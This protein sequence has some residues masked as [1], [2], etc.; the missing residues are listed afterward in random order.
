MPTS[1]ETHAVDTSVAVAA[2]DASHAAHDICRARVVALRP[3]LAGN[4]ASESF[5]VLTRMPGQLSADGATAYAVLDRAFPE[6]CW[7]S[8]DQAHRLLQRCAEMEVVGG[9]FYEALVGESARVA[10]RRLLTRD[11]RARRIYDLLG[12]DYE[13]VGL[14]D[15]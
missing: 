12:I 10:G 14:P 1:A 3:A 6:R 11:R 9:S 5:A 13:L 15:L 4:A 8:G 2:V 7:L